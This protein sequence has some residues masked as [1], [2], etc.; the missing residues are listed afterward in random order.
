MILFLSE[1][2]LRRLQLVW[3]PDLNAFLIGH[4]NLFFFAPDSIFEIDRISPE[5]IDQF[6]KETRI[7][8][9]WQLL[10]FLSPQTTPQLAGYARIET[11]GQFDPAHWKAVIALLTESELQDKPLEIRQSKTA[12]IR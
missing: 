9:D 12:A 5:S 11:R 8:S 7:P 4:R 1:S 6:L 2:F 3:K 10:G